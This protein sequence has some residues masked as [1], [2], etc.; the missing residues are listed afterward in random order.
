[1]GMELGS[2]ILTEENSLM[3]FENTALTGCNR[4]RGKNCIMRSFMSVTALQTLC[5]HSN[6][7]HVTHK[8]DMGIDRRMLYHVLTFSRWNYFFK[9]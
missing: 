1:M 6:H 7:V 2:L 4:D 9:F 5:Y 8:G 3:A